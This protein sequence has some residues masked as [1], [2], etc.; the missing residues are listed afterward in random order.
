M[1]ASEKYAELCRQIN[2]CVIVPTYNNATSLGKLLESFSALTG[3]VIVVN[4]GSTDHTRQVLEAYR[5]FTVISYTRN[6]GKGYAIR[7]GFAAALKA[8]YDHAITIDSD[9]QHRPEDMTALL[10]TSATEP[11]A[12]LIGSRNLD[13]EGIPRGTTFGNRFSNFWMRVET[14]LSLPDTQSGYRLYPIRK[15]ERMRFFTNRFEF[16]IEV[17][18][19]AAWKGIRILPVPVRVHYPPREKRISHFR[20]FTDFARISLLNS[21]LVILALLYFRPFLFLRTLDRENIRIF[22]RKYLLSPD[23]SNARKAASIGL[24]VCVGILPIW[25]WQ[26]ATAIALSFFFRLNKVLTVVASNISIPPMIPL[27][28]YGSYL[29]GGVI[30]HSRVNAAGDIDYTLEFVKQNLIQYVVGAVALAIL[31]GVAASLLTWTL[32]SL[33]RKKQSMKAEHADAGGTMDSILK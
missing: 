31:A 28:L 5:G 22:Y 9:G 21:V 17:L 30:L 1:S 18:V 7:Q 32:L 13:Q 11:G 2:C 24:G 26:I 27:I 25:G 10:E 14:G 33:F 23:E 15:L 16:E 3:R 19:R 12:L 6:R 8:G 4:D 20:P 29:L